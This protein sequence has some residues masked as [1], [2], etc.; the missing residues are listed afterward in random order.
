MKKLALLLLAL[1]LLATPCYSASS[2]TATTA[3]SNTW[4]W[5]I[6]LTWT[7]HTDGSFT[8]VATPYID[9]MVLMAETNPGATAPTANYDITL[10]S[11]D[12]VDVFG[13]A[14]LN[15]HTSTS[16]RSM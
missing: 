13:G 3:K 6:T 8:S 12:G 1:L 15:R 11:S 2:M 9:G 5:C 7:A 10:T 16:E 4:L 14:L